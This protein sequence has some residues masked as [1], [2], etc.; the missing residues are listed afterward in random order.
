MQSRTKK[1]VAMFTLVVFAADMI[2][3][4][5]FAFLV[6]SS[7]G[8][9]ECFLFLCGLPVGMSAAFSFGST[10]VKEMIDF[11]S[12]NLS[13]L[14]RSWFIN[15]CSRCAYSLLTHRS[16]SWYVSV[17]FPAIWALEWHNFGSLLSLLT[18][19]FNTSI[20]RIQY[21][22]PPNYL[23][24]SLAKLCQKNEVKS[25]SDLSLLVLTNLNS[26]S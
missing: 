22:E 19:V 20:H 7:T 23:A 8:G 18:K 2:E 5:S 14:T 15:G 10:I 6:I 26:A 24:P 1:Q 11:A 21:R 16:L 3:D 13:L 4:S 12:A 9:F 25:A 17:G